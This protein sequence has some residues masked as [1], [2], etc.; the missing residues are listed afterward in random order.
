MPKFL[1]QKEIYRLIQRELPEDVYPDG[2]PSDFK[3]TASVQAKAK[4]IETTYSNMARIYDNFF[5]QLADEQILDWEIKIFGFQLDS[6][7]TLQDRREAI[8]AKIRNQSRT[9]PQDMVDI[10]HQVVPADVP[11]EALEWNCGGNGWILDFSQLG[12]STI[13]NGFNGLKF[14]G[15]TELCGKTAA[16]WGLSEEDFEDYQNQAYSYDLK[17]YNYTL[18]AMQ[19][20]ELNNRL[21]AGE[22]ARSRHY[23]IDGLD[24]DT[25]ALGGDS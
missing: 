1:I 12:I 4:T 25:E 6:A 5:P 11:V 18:T 7:L 13:L 24:Y 17:I 21:L 10:A 22:P 16:D 2:N 9:T 14:L 15:G 19:E 20:E 3:S 23:I 8:L